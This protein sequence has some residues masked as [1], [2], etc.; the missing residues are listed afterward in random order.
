MK[1]NKKIMEKIA[2]MA[3]I[4]LGSAHFLSSHIT[5]SEDAQGAIIEMLGDS[6][7]KVSEMITMLILKN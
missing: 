2:W 6:Y 5:L 4:L 3:A 1:K 7:G